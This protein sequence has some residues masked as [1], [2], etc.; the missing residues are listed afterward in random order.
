MKADEPIVW[1]ALGEA[2]LASADAAVTAAKAAKT[3]TNDPAILQKYTDAAASYQKAIDLNVAKSK[4][5]PE[6][7]YSSY[8]NQGQALGRSGKTTEGCCGL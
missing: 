5:N 1:A 3:P 4:P 2:Q 6:I 7:T 8:L